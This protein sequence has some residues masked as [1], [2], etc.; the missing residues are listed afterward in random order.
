MHIDERLRVVLGVYH[1]QEHAETESALEP[2]HARVNVLG[3][4]EVIA[5]AEKKAAFRV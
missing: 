2:L 1:A 4:E 3:L 5:E